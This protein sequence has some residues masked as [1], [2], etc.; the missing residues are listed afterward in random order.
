MFSSL[1]TDPMQQ[2]GT[3]PPASVS[4]GGFGNFPNTGTASQPIDTGAKYAALA[5]LFSDNTPSTVQSTVS[6]ASAPINWGGG[7]AT[8]SAPANPGAINWS[9]NVPNSTSTGMG[10]TWNTPAAAANTN[11]SN[12]FNSAGRSSFQFIL[13]L[14]QSPHREVIV[15]HWLK[16]SMQFLMLD[17]IYTLIEIS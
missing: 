11:S 13:L 17:V 10:M 7:G 8:T 3:N 4:N 14:L 2:M 9:G 1:F 16:H 15:C 6:V 5:D 12:M